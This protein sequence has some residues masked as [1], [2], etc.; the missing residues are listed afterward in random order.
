MEHVAI[1]GITLRRAVLGI[2]LAA[3]APMT[4]QEVVAELHRQGVT[5][6][7]HLKKEPHRVIADLLAHQARI[8]KVRRVRRGVYVVIS[9]SMSRSTRWRCLHWRDRLP[10]SERDEPR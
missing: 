1:A 6:L 2:L 7:P 10:L 4:P 8:G 9:N 5:T 3:H